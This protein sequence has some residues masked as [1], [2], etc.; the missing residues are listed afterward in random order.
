MHQSLIDSVGRENALKLMGD[1][2]FQA[3]EENSTSGVLRK[4]KTAKV[5]YSIP[6]FV[7]DGCQVPLGG[8]PSP[9]SR[10]LSKKVPIA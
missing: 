3:I 4:A 1:A 8:A 5:I 10:S 2:V 7:E 9:A 6:C